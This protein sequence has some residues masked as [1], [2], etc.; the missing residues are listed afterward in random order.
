MRTPI[1]TTFT[2]IKNAIPFYFLP[3]HQ[4]S[5]I[6]IHALRSRII[7]SAK[8]FNFNNTFK[9]YLCY[10]IF[11]ISRQ[12]KNS[13]CSHTHILR[14]TE[15]LQQ[16][17]VQRRQPPQNSVY[18]Q[19]CICGVS[20]GLNREGSFVIVTLCIFNH[21]SNFYLLRSIEFNKFHL[22]NR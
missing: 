12:I 20:G 15:I 2:F 11:N 19:F 5:F 21:Y 4:F 10:T 13:L 14:I 7:C 22:Y 6:F 17:P 9:L 8:K 18:G 1:L 16:T 3:T